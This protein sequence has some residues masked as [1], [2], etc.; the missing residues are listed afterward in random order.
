MKSLALATL[1]LATSAS[2]F[3]PIS[4]Q[5][6]AGAA[7]TTAASSSSA[8]NALAD[9]IF[10]MDLFDPNRNKYG[11]R[12]NK[13]LKSGALT[14]KSYIPTGLSK[15]EYEKIRA[16]DVAKKEA[17]YKKNVAKAGIFEDFTKFYLKRGTA[18]GGSWLKAPA[19][20]HR[21]A[22]TKFDWSDTKDAKLFESAKVGPFGKKK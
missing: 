20:G 7:A 5:S 13:N 15:A 16:R 17:S 3:A 9:N 19:R 6:P 8:L 14:D 10:G 1:F 4:C 22:K 2:A 18:E 12:S 21:M 11:A